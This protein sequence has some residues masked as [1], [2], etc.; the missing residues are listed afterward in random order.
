VAAVTAAV[1]AASRRAAELV[2]GVAEAPVWALTDAEVSEAVAAIQQAMGGLEA[3]QS[4]LVRLAEEREIP[5]S[6]GAASTTAWLAGATRT[7]KAAAARSVKTAR[8]CD[9]GVVLA[10]WSAGIINREQVQV[11]VDAV[12]K[13]PAWFG[14]TERH[15]AAASLVEHA[16]QFDLDDLKRLANRIIE[17][18]DPD[19]ADD[20]LGEQVKREEERAWDATRLRMR[21]GADGLTRGDFQIPDQFADQLRAAVEALAA[22]R[23]KEQTAT[24]WGLDLD[25]V[26][27]L[28]REQ[29]LGLAFCELIEHLPEDAL[30]QSGGLA[31]TVG[32]FVDVD[33]MRSG[34]GTATT[35]TG[36]TVSAATAQRLACN[37]HLVGLYLNPDG[38][39]TCTTSPGRLYSKNQRIALATRDRG[40]VW[41]G[42][43]RPPA[44]CEA[45]HLIPWSHGGPTTLEN[46]VLLCF[47][48][49]HLLHEGRAGHQGGWQLRRADD[50]IAEVV[51]PERLDPHR[52]PRRHA[53]YTPLRP[54]AA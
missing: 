40:C 28:P 22:P 46:G 49:H 52:T 2:S 43:D 26:R 32:V 21:R 6:T 9:E 3:M 8:T 14:E 27:R 38:Q 36:S 11:I 33:T 54:R 42:C 44:Q 34:H 12:A 41:A 16:Q 45:H 18:V 20:L 24:R 29:R 31:A 25:D 10:A 39:V 13:L 50:G 15:D 35:S 7:S 47:F 51:P 5:R 1:L 48:H 37:A 53:R 23:R 4:Q 30:P 19:G 17:V